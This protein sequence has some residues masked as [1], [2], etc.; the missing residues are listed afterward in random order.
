MS[1]LYD[2]AS[3]RILC[4]CIGYRPEPT[5]TTGVLDVPFAD[6]DAEMVAGGQLMA[7]PVADLAFDKAAIRA[8]G[9]DALTISG[10]PAS[11]VVRFR[12]QAYSPE[13]GFVS[14]ISPVPGRFKVVVECWPE[15]GTIR[16]LTAQ[17]AG[18]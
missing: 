18:G 4:L 11:A 7:R 14:L 17:A 12:G 5:A 15:R 6:P 9:Q 3:G 2:L 8:D 16:D 1:V 10:L 13:G